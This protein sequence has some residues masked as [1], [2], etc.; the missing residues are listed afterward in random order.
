MQEQ[1][2]NKYREL[3]N[4]D[5]NDIKRKYER[6][7]CQNMSKTIRLKEYR[8]SYRDAK[9]LG[10]FSLHSMKMNEQILNFDY[11]GVNRNIFHKRKQPIN[12]NQIDIRKKVISNKD[13]NGKKII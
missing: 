12:I 11:Y 9:T 3:S 2:R 10:S 1:A 8:K 6:N 4:E 7:R 13:S 5:E